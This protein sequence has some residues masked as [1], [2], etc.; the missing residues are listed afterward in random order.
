[1]RKKQTKKT[2]RKRTAKKKPAPKR[3]R[4]RIT[5]NEGISGNTSDSLLYHTDMKRAEKL[6]E[7]N[8]NQIMNHQNRSHFVMIQEIFR[9]GIIGGVIDVRLKDIVTNK[10]ADVIVVKNINI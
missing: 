6:R 1:M 10:R 5:D 8:G 4:V 2:A 7:T 9:N 3:K